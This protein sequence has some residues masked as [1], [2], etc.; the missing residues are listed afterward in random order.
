MYGKVRIR[1]N[2]SNFLLTRPPA[3]R[4]VSAAVPIVSNISCEPVFL[5][6]RMKHDIISQV[7][8]AEDR[9]EQVIQQAHA[10]ADQMVRAARREAADIQQNLLEQAKDE[11]NAHFEREAAAIEPEIAAIRDQSAADIAADTDQ[12]GT[13]LDAAVETVVT[14]FFE[15]FTQG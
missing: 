5:G 8:D 1:M 11:A 12:A 14:R 15:H 13:R 9:A 4:T 7:R 10:E 3:S 2:H 6:V